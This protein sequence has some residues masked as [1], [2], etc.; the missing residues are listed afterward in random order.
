MVHSI[1]VDTET[2]EKILRSEKKYVI[3][4]ND[5]RYLAGDVIVYREFAGVEYTGRER[6]KRVIYSVHDPEV[7][8]EGKVL[9]FV[10]TTTKGKRGKYKADK[11]EGKKK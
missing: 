8:K 6:R 5:R 3:R 1:R 9:V 7:I 4:P 10:E 11:T 2:Y